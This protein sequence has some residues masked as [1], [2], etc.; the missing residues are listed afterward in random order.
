[1]MKEKIKA[2]K[3]K[4]I[5]FIIKTLIFII[6]GTVIWCVSATKTKNTEKDVEENIAADE[7]EEAVE[8]IA[9]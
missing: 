5:L 8:I 7:I 1:M 2:K 9:G 6:A 4:I 3:K